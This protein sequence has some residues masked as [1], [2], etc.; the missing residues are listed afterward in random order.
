V[1]AAITEIIDWGIARGQ[2]MLDVLGGLWERIGNSVDY[3]LNYLATDFIPGIAKFVKGAL[4]AGYELARLVVF[5][6]GKIFEVTLEVVRGML[7]AGVTLAELFVETLKHPDQVLQNMARAARQLGKTM[8]EIGQA[9]RDAGEE[10]A[11]EFA[12]TM[13]AIGENAKDMLLAVLEIEVGWLDTVLFVLM[14]FLNGFRPLTDDEKADAEL[15]FADTVDLDKVRIATESPTN[16]IIFGIQDFFTGEPES[17]AFVTGNL[18]NFDADDIPPLKRY[19][20]IHEMTHV[21]QHQNVGPIYMAHALFGQA[22]SGYNYGYQEST[23]PDDA[24]VLPNGAY[25]GSEQ[26][27]PQGF[28]DGFGAESALAAG[29][30]DITTFNPEQQGQ[31][32]MH[33]FVR[34]HLLNQTP[35]QYAAWQPYVDFVQS[36][37]PVA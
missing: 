23:D 1:G 33:Y 3:A 21:W 26:R 22:T 30:G 36:H 31:I 2:D 32:M 7:E 14:T 5:T 10:F 8:N 6:A 17:R 20:F 19:T 18:I 13:V 28:A 24:V 29:G 9:F 34:R 16:S 37:P 12:R 11:D 4:G 15:M 25:D 35:A 27:E